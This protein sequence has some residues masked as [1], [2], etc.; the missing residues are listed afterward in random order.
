MSRGAAQ[1]GNITFLFTVFS[2][3]LVSGGAYLLERSRQNVETANQK[4]QEANEKVKD[5]D[6]KVRE[7]GNKVNEITRRVEHTEQVAKDAMKLA[8]SANLAVEKSETSLGISGLLSRGTSTSWQLRE[9]KTGTEF[10]SLVPH[11]R[12]LARS[13]EGRL[14]DAADRNLLGSRERDLFLEPMFTIRQNL[15]ALPVE[16]RKQMQDII[17]RCNRIIELL[18]EI[19]YG[20]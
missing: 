3:A 8:E 15:E 18:K 16:S 20:E 9:L 1:P 11:Q 5:A 13:I 14:R 4:V 10:E 19:G 6:S 12:D 2:V 7:A 17:E